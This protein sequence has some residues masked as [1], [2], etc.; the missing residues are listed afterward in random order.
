[1]RVTGGG[2]VSQ[3]DVQFRKSILLHITAG[4]IASGA[5]AGHQRQAKSRAHTQR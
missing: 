3:R 4:N 1:M 2:G 5:A